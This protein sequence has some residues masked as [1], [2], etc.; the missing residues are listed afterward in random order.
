MRALVLLSLIAFSACLPDD[1]S[2]PDAGTAPLFVDGDG[3]P[4]LTGSITTQGAVAPGDTL[5]AQ[6]PVDADTGFVRLAVED[7]ATS[8]SLVQNFA[9]ESAP[10]S[11]FEAELEIPIGTSAAPGTYY[12]TV[13]LCSVSICNNPFKRVTYERVGESD[14]YTRVDF[15]SPPLTQIGDPRD[16]DVVINTFELQ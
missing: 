10:S 2:E 7:F 14:T 12:L 1:N 11:T 15:D 9:D 3:F 6:V 16:S 4:E 5:V 13:D 8:T